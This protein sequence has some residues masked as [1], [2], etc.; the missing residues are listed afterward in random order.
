MTNRNRC[1]VSRKTCV[2]QLRVDV[3][4][5]YRL[6]NLLGGFFKGVLRSVSVEWWGG[7][8]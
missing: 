1:Y 6:T 2:T 4:P 7:G 8:E 5:F 3:I